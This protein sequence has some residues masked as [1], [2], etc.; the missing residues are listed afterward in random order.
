MK[1]LLELIGL[2]PIVVLS[3]VF[4]IGADRVVVVPCVEDLE[5]RVNADEAMIGT[6][7]QLQGG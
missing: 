1:H 3:T 5:A 7:F 4:L 2:A 6:R